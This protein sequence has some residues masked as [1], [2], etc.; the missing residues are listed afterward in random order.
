[1]ASR[2]R[3]TSGSSGGS[4]GSSARGGSVVSHASSQ[5]PHGPVRPPPRTI[6]KDN[7]RATSRNGHRGSRENLAMNTA[8]TVNTSS[9]HGIPDIFQR[10]GIPGGPGF[11]AGT[12]FPPH[13]DN[14]P[15]PPQRQPP[16]NL[17]IR[18]E[19]TPRHPLHFPPPRFNPP[20]GARGRD[21]PARGWHDTLMRDNSPQGRNI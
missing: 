4:H 9:E 21:S 11:P 3:T 6:S 16:S 19:P 18:P 8:T 7:L 2:I 13:R 20:P 14:S 1:M 12:G 10:S 15:Q 17:G 5:D